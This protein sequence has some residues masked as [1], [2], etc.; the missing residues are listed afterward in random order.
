MR[1]VK[2]NE[3][4]HEA[5]SVKKKRKE[6]IKTTKDRML[7]IK[8]ANENGGM[9][10]IVCGREIKKNQSFRELPKDKSCQEVRHYHLRTCGP[11][12]SN[13]KVFKVNGK[14]APK[15]SPLKG[16]LSFHWKEGKR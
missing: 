16:Q 5:K 7:N 15:S 10:C 12:S 9:E 8:R 6:L 1:R 11:G 4:Q 13:W 2:Q 3:A 14:K